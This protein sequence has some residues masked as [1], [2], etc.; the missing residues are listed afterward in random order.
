MNQ[1]YQLWRE[2]TFSE[3]WPEFIAEK[4]QAIGPKTLL[5]YRE[6]FRMLNPFFG[7]IRLL[8]IRITHVVAYRNSRPTAGAGLINHEINTLSQVLNKAGLW[9]ELGQ[10][11]KQ[12]P[13]PKTGP[14]QAFLPAEALWLLEVA[15]RHKRWQ[16]AYLC[17]LL[18]ANTACGPGEIRNLRHRDINLHDGVGVL[19]IVDGAKND[20]RVRTVPLNPDA[21]WALEQL[22]EVALAKGSYKPEHYLVPARPYRL[23]GPKNK[24]QCHADPDRPA[25]SW[26]KAWYALRKEAAKK[27]PKLANIRLYDLRHHVL[28]TMLENPAISEQTIKAI[29]GHVS[30]KILERY[31]HIRIAEKQAALSSLES[32]RPA[33]A[34]PVRE[35]VIPPRRP[36]SQ[37]E[38]DPLEILWQANRKA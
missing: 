33:P 24:N 30:K 9:A 8:D 26:R 14:G 31:S 20:Y 7:E 6:Y 23:I 13:L 17:S 34:G 38:Q 25:R 5:C 36:P 29:A 19:N 37:A 21:R 15:S 22:Q 16:T 3:V 1:T 18:S 11:Y 10:F 12:L 27:Y 2:R 32:L 28:T 35:V 4:S